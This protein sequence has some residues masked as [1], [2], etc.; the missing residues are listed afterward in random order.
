MKIG[1]LNKWDRGGGAARAAYRLFEALEQHGEDVHYGVHVRTV[2]HPRVVEIPFQNPAYCDM[3]GRVQRSLIDCNRSTRSKTYFSSTFNHVDWWAVPLLTDVDVINLHWVEKFVSPAGLHQLCSMGKPV[4]W[5]LHDQRPFTGGCHYTAGCEGFSDNG[6][7]Q[8]VQLKND[9]VGLP[10]ANL[11]A[12]MAA[13]ALAEKFVAV[14]PSKWLAEE[15]KRSTLFRNKRIELIPNSVETNIFRPI[16]KSLAKQKIGVPIDS[17]SIMFGAHDTRDTRKG[18]SFLIKAMRSILREWKF[19]EMANEGRLNVLLAGAPKNFDLD[20]PVRVF[21]FGHVSDDSLL[22]SIY[23]A[24][25]V[26]VLPSLEDNLPNTMLESMACGTPVIGF[27]IGG[28]P[29]LVSN[30]QTGFLVRYQSHVALSI[31]IANAIRNPNLMRQLEAN[32]IDLIRSKYTQKHQAQRYI[33]LFTELA[34]SPSVTKESAPFSYDQFTEIF[35]YAWT[36]TV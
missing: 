18:F 14:A 28:I 23:S 31:A 25:N 2:D 8:C 26:F 21:N 27:D 3:D 16:D 33:D 36:N 30:G 10:L 15:A 13:A 19:L 5:T 9:V 34:A 4:V 7:R 6:C 1:M 17:F 29:D 12:R 11:T 24:S 22:S 20:L 35:G 32:C